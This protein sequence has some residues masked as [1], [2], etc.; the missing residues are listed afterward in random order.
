[1]NFYNIITC[2]SFGASGSGVVTDYLREYSGIK[3]MGDYEF[4]FL[5][6]YDGVST[7]EDA[8]IH[9]P[10][11]LNSD[12]AIQN[13]KRYVDRQCG[14]F[15]N[16]RYERFFNGQWKKISEVFLKKIIDAEWPGYWEQYQIM[17]PSKFHAFIKYQLYP[18]ILRLLAGNRKY[19][20]HYL[21][22]KEMYF[23]A[24]SEDYFL[25]SVK[26]YVRELCNVIDPR[27]EYRYLFMDQLMPPANISKYERYFDSIKTIV[28]DR[29]PRDYYIENVLRSGEGWVPKSVENFVL[30]FRKHREQ[31]KAFTDSSNVLRLKFEDTIFKYDEFENSVRD[32]LEL[33]K[34]E[35]ISP[36]EHFDPAKSVQNTRLWTKRKVNIA[37]IDQI[38][39]LLPE[40]LYDFGAN[41]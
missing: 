9:S 31:A 11:R 38:E 20:A 32:F 23:S 3:N 40:F 41:Q 27:H 22:Q 36:K 39:K 4:R 30:L 18:R 14:T 19:I 29:D 26:E 15:L 33:D 28:V 34:R 37:I 25:N 17:G 16:R 1:M 2:A 8:L 24:P 21:P 12:I 10:H 6:D 35:H 7:L 13:F 5:Q